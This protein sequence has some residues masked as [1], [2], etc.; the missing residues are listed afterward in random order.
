VNYIEKYQL[1]SKVNISYMRGKVKVNEA[2][3]SL[4]KMEDGFSVFDNIKGIPR[5]WQ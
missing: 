5:H 2:G 3:K 4:L 1:Q